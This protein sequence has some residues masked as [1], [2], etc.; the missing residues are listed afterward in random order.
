MPRIVMEMARFE[1]CP[2]KVTALPIKNLPCGTWMPA[3]LG[4]LQA[5]F[6]APRNADV[7]SVV[8]SGLAP[9][10]TTL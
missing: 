6:H 8:P 4:E 9:K 7:A 2:L 3:G 1:H 10:S 5:L